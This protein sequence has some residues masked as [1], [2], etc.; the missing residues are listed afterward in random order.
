MAYFSIDTGAT[1]YVNSSL[2]ARK[3]VRSRIEA[4]G[5]KTIEC[6]VGGA[7]EIVNEHLF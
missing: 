4:L 5:I 7:A 3:E 1:V 2:E 6:S